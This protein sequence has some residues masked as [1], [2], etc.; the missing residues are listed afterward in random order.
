VL[1]QAV[2]NAK[3]DKLLGLKENVLVGHLIPAGTG[4]HAY[5]NMIVASKE[6]HDSITNSKENIKIEKEQ[7]IAK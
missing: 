4:M 7:V 6:E 5:R 3:V 2:I 1:T